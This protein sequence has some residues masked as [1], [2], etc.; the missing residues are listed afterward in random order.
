[1]KWRAWTLLSWFVSVIFLQCGT[2]VA[3]GIGMVI[4]CNDH[5]ARNLFANLSFVR[6][7]LG[8]RLPVEIWYAGDE[9]SLL[10][11]SLLQ[12]LGKIT[13][14]DIAEILGGN[15][16]KYRGY[17]I[18]GLAL[19]ASTLDEIILADADLFFFQSPTK[20]LKYPRSREYGALFFRDREEFCFQDYQTTRLWYH[21]R[22]YTTSFTYAQRKKIVRHLIPKPNKSIDRK[23]VV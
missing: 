8:C 10:N 9:L 17:H 16:E 6:T 14:H 15:P 3:Q 4:A 5:Y 11:K 18:K 13:F 2:L 21:D 20:L 19:A 7:A 22:H 1:M 12:S 23:S